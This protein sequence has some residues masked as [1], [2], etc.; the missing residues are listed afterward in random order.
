MNYKRLLFYWVTSFVIAVSGYYLLSLIFYGVFG[1]LYRMVLYHF[2]H[3]I[4]YI[5]IPCFFYGLMA[6]SFS[7]RFLE[8]ETK[9]KVLTTMLII[10]LTILLSSP[11]GGM[12]WFLHDMQ[13]GYFPADWFI[14]MMIQG[15]MDGIA[16]G[17][18]IILLSF[19]YNILGVVVCYFLTKK[20]SELFR[21]G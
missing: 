8:K 4:Q 14:K 6:T 5:L 7:D 11:F 2:D 21:E 19:P 20:G 3:P 18:L 10:F 15:G 16:I 9:G 13:A 17:W 1:S 12:L